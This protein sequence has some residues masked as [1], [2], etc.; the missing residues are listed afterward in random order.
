MVT[1]D[2]AARACCTELGVVFTGTIGILKA[3]CLQKVL[4]P[5]TADSILQSMIAS[6]Y[7]S[8]V[9]RVSDIL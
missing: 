6:G 7:R 2:R 1:D 3:C 9:G 4:D 5:D 8:P